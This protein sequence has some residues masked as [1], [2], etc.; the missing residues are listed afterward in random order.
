[1]RI[2]RP[3]LSADKRRCQAHFFCTTFCSAAPLA[4]I[5]PHCSA[6]EYYH[7]LCIVRSMKGR[8]K[9]SKNK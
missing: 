7:A 3:S 5:A 9:T 8:K 6:H 2:N 1:L 4:Q